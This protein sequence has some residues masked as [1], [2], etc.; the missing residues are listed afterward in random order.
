MRTLTIFLLAI[1]IHL[2]Y[3][4]ETNKKDIPFTEKIRPTLMKW[5]GEHK[6]EMLIGKAPVV[7]KDD[8]VPMPKIPDV[9]ENATSTEIYSKKADKVILKPELEEKY[10]VGYIR[11]IYEATR[12]QKPNDDEIGKFYNVLSQGGTREGVYRNLVLDSTYGNLENMEGLAVKSMSADFA[13]FFYQKYA[14]KTISKDKFKG[15]NTYSLKRV[16]AEKALE[17]IDSFG[18]DRAGLEAWYAN[19]SS[20]MA[21]KFQQVMQTPLRKNTS[22]QAHQQWAQ[23]VPV[24]HIK[25]ETI[26]KIH[27]AFNSLM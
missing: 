9:K 16:V 18:E 10:F 17:I 19:L 24:Q 26:I 15:W 25:S 1:S 2:L 4:A 3:A 8:S 12:K 23:K 6:T 5:L 7:E 22:S 11:E 13:V 27:T 14:N 21:F 20:D